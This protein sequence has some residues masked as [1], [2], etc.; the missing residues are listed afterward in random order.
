MPNDAN[1]QQLSHCIHLETRPSP[2]PKVH[3]ACEHVCIE[4]CGVQVRCDQASLVSFPQGVGSSFRTTRAFQAAASLGGPSPHPALSKGH[5][6]FQIRMGPSRA[7]LLPRVPSLLCPLGEP[8]RWGGHKGELQPRGVAACRLHSERGDEELGSHG[9]DS[10]C[11][12]LSWV[13]PQARVM[14]ATTRPQV[15]QRLHQPARLRVAW[16]PKGALPP[17]HPPLPAS[18]DAVRLF[19]PFTVPECPPD[20]VTQHPPG[21]REATRVST[22]PGEAV[23][24]WPG[25]RSSEAPRE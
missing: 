23:L 20:A 9:T 18:Q 10:N 2:I 24:V 12:H 22:R 14:L 5:C 3:P 15:C 4:T 11:V 17:Q 13:G 8:Q 1:A 6:Q 7:R 25:C 21:A 16:A 19:T